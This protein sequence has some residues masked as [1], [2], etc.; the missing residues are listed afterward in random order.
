MSASSASP[1][2]VGQAT[3]GAF[4]HDNKFEYY[5]GRQ[6]AD[7][8]PSEVQ[9]IPAA[10]VEHSPEITEVDHD[11][12]GDSGNELPLSL[13][14][15]RSPITFD[16]T[17]GIPEIQPS[18]TYVAWSPSLA[19]DTGSMYGN[20]G[21]VNTPEV[22]ESQIESVRYVPYA[23]FHRR[24]VKLLTFPS[25]NTVPNFSRPVREHLPSQRFRRM[26]EY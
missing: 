8:F 23:H 24:D 1:T 9:L 7:G 18:P 2:A 14:I 4:P 11:S 5:T 12:H 25:N 6:L 13:A 19:Q 10:L 20:S 17:V 26:E 15:R 22:E 21:E 3:P 16:E